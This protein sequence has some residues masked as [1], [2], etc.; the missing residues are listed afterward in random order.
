VLQTEVAW[1]ASRRAAAQSAPP[2]ARLRSCL[3]SWPGQEPTDAVL[4]RMQQ[5]A[6][7]WDAGAMLVAVRSRSRVLLTAEGGDGFP[8]AV[9]AALEVALSSDP[10]GAVRVLAGPAG[11]PGP[12]RATGPRGGASAP[13]G[14]LTWLLGRLDARQAATFIEHRLAPVV[15]HDREHGTDLQGVLEL[16]LDHPHR[17]E[18]ADA[19]YM[20]RNT[21]RRQLDR[22]LRLL[23]VDLRR[24]DERLALHLALKLRRGR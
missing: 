21:F 4:E 19:A 7:R 22:A 1:A 12:E 20:H 15:A 17:H 8:G 13:C 16:A 10:Q 24:P 3:F 23:D 6:R 2:G 18:A 5:A 11:G 9:A 14:S